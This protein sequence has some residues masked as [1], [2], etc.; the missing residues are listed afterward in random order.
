M[1]NPRAI[2]Y[3][4]LALAEQ[5]QE[6]ARLLHRLAEEAEQGIL[7][8]ADWRRPSLPP[9]PSYGNESSARALMAVQ[10]SPR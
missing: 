2:K 8:T 6:K 1:N 5:D 7:V 10:K 3:R 9:L 4:R